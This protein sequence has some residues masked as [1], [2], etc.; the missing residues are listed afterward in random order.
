MS[1]TKVS[2]FPVRRSLV[3]QISTPSDVQKAP[4]RTRANAPRV[5]SGCTTCKIRR[6]KCDEQKPECQRCISTGR[7]CDGYAPLH[8]EP[9]VHSIGSTPTLQA[10]P[11]LFLASQEELRALQYFHLNTAPQLASYF[12]AEFW[13]RLV[14]QAA[15]EED[16]VRHAMIALGWLSERRI[17]DLV[18]AQASRPIVVAHR[19]EHLRDTSSTSLPYTGSQPDDRFTLAQYNKAITALSARMTGANDSSAP[20][21]TTNICG[22]HHR[23]QQPILHTK[24]SFSD[25]FR[26]GKNAVDALILSSEVSALD[27]AGARALRLHMLICQIWTE[28]APHPAECKHDEFLPH[29]EKAVAIAEAITRPDDSEERPPTFLFDMEI[30]SPIYFVGLQCRNPSVRRRAIAV[31]KSSMRR[32]GLWDSHKAAA[33]TERVMQI[34]ERNLSALDGSE[35]PAEDDRIHGVNILS[36]PGTFPRQLLLTY[37]AKPDGFGG[38][39]KWQEELVLESHSD[40]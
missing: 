31:L 16:C 32:E 37:L 27:L 4:K 11:T 40:V 23:F 9:T 3:S 12:D 20:L 38:W 28:L 33:V 8:K 21:Q 18:A 1:D 17:G 15:H 14:F 22:L 10:A 26:P 36:E 2:T 7:K 25:N 6:V 19:T 24:A 29:F 30:V 13:T 39:E 35:L 5:R 34:E